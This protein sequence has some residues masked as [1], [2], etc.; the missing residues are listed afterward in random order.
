MGNSDYCL[1]RCNV[2][3]TLRKASGQWGQNLP[4]EMK[5]IC[6]RR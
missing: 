3:R 4:G 6:V 2:I 1:H 5:L